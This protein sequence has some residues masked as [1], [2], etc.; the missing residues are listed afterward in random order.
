VFSEPEV[1]FDPPEPI[2]LHVTTSQTS[3]PLAQSLSV[4]EKQLRQMPGPPEN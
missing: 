3:P 4:L 2:E 1:Q